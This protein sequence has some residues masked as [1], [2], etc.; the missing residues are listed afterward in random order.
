MAVLTPLRAAFYDEDGM[1]WVLLETVADGAFL[2]DIAFTF[3]SAY[4]DSIE[5][6]V[7]NRRQIACGYLRSWFVLDLIA[8]LPI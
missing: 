2:L 1:T 6:L 5:R 3:C 8:V 7:S 4:Y